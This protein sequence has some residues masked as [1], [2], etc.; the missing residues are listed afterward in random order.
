MVLL[1]F[2]KQLE[3]SENRLISAFGRG[4]VLMMRFRG[5]IV[6]CWSRLSA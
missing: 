1:S 4:L 2:R 6:V 5:Q 3:T